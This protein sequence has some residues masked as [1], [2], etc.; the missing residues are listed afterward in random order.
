MFCLKTYSP[1]KNTGVSGLPFP[2]PGDLPNPGIEP[3]SPALW[4]DSLPSEPPG[5]SKRQKIVPQKDAFHSGIASCSY[6]LLSLSFVLFIPFVT[7][8]CSYTLGDISYHCCPLHSL[9]QALINKEFDYC[10]AAFS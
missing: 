7:E 5:K 6:L 9:V 8:Y 2:P 10:I 1:G 3:R 4:T